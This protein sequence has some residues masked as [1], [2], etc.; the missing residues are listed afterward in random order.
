M[1]YLTA[2]LLASTLSACG[3]STW[4]TIPS[5]SFGEYQHTTAQP[6]QRWNSTDGGDGG[7]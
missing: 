3:T 4:L 6:L 2:L 7:K 1:K 5:N